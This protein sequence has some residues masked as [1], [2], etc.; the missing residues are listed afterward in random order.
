[1]DFHIRKN[2]TLPTLKVKVVKDGRSDF[3]NLYDYLN[4]STITFSMTDVVTN[5]PKIVSAPCTTQLLENPID[6]T[7]EYFINYQ[8]TERE[9]KEEGR[10]KAT[11]LIENSQGDLILPLTEE[12]YINI[13]ESFSE[14]N[15]CC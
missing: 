12:L 13:L 8:F 7:T 4:Q 5:L 3:V 11:F 2:A 1:M 6:N 15:I 14:T 9:T 10:F